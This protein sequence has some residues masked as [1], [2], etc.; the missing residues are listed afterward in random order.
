[1]NRM[2]VLAGVVWMV[3]ATTAAHQNPSGIIEETASFDAVS[4]KPNTDRI[5]N[6]LP[7]SRG[8]GNYSASNVA[9]RSLVAI[10]YGVRGFQIEGG[11]NWLTSERFD[12]VARGPE[13]TP[14]RL[15]AAMLRSMLAERFKFVAHF[16]IKEQSVYS[17]SALRDDGRLG[18]QMKLSAQAPDVATGSPSAFP[19]SWVENGTVNIRGSHVSMDTLSMMLTDLVFNRRV[20][21]RTGLNGEF[22]IDLRFSQ[23]SPGVASEFPSVF[24]ALQEQL[25]LKAEASRGPVEVLI[26]DSVERPTPN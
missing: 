4:I 24:T 18:P 19:S 8:N 7:I 1:M 14:D 10:A 3:G 6:A 11:P 12:I 15:R 17:L 13:G 21:N 25:G 22:Q 23:E 2:T 9:V 16:E 5:S 26:I 20:I